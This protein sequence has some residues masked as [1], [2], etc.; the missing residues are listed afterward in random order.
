M[1]E[2]PS[3]N[4]ELIAALRT[5]L[6]ATLHAHVPSLA[7]LLLAAAGGTRPVAEVERDLATASFQPLLTALVGQHIPTSSNGITVSAESNQRDATI[8]LTVQ[9]AQGSYIAQADRGSNA[10]VI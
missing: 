6:P 2:P 7:E 4:I 5:A 8:A 9:Y 3:A 1:S 10:M